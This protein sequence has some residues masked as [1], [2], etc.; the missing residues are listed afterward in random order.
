MKP[1]AMLVLLAGAVEGLPV[2][3]HIRRRERGRRFAWLQKRLN[4]HLRQ[5]CV[6]PGVAPRTKGRKVVLTILCTELERPRNG[7]ARPQ[8]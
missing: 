8:I 7:I 2:A 1:M 4:E 6:A 5:H 3:D